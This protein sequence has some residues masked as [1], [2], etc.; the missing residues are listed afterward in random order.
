MPAIDIPTLTNWLATGLIGLFF[1]VISAWVAYRYERRRDDIAWTREKDKLR[2]QFEHEKESLA[3]QFQQK[4][5][6]INQQALHE[7]K[8]QLRSSLLAGVENPT[9]AITNM[10]HFQRELEP[11]RAERRIKGLIRIDTN[12]LGVIIALATQLV[13][14]LY[15][16]QAQMAGRIPPNM[17]DSVAQ[18]R[19]YIQSLQNMLMSA[20]GVEDPH[21]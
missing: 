16:L 14:H 12:E 19:S 8:S 2:Q 7:Q 10:E 9:E 3:S 21:G 6:E 1:G 5:E 11:Q 20:D 18:V 15:H 17:V 13:N 4:L